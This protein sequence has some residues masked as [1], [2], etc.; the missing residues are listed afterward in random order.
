[1]IDVVFL[2][3]TFFIFAMVMMVRADVLDLRLPTLGSGDTAPRTGMIII[4]IDTDGSITLDAEPAELETIAELVATRIAETSD[5]RVIIA[6]DEDA[7]AGRVFAVLDRLNAV[8]ISD[9]SVFGR[10]ADPP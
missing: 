10:P 4:A 2:L 7:P 9:V 8:G 6:T 1:M 3:L 5:A